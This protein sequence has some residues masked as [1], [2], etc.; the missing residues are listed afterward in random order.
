MNIGTDQ[1][2]SL[3]KTRRLLL[4]ANQ[5]AKPRPDVKADAP[6]FKDIMESGDPPATSGTEFKAAGPQK[7]GYIQPKEGSTFEITT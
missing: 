1:I 7:S 3:V 6:S 4:L 5:A 2:Q